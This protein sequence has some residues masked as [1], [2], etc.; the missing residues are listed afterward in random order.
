MKKRL[1]SYISIVVT[2]SLLL[3]FGLGLLVTR[4]NNNEITSDKLTEIT[5][6]LAS[7][8]D[9]NFDNLCSYNGNIRITVI[10]SNGTVIADSDEVDV[11]T[12]DNHIDREEVVAALKGAPTII[13]RYSSTIGRD[14]MYYAEKVS[15]G[16]DYVFI[17]TAMP[18][19]SISGYLVKTIPLMIF[20]LFFVLAMS[21]IVSFFVSDKLIK[22]YTAVKENLQAINNGNYKKLMPTESYSEINETITEINDIAEKINLSIATTNEEKNRLDYVVNNINDGIIAVDKDGNLQMV[23]KK[24]AE[25]FNAE[26]NLV[27]KG[28]ESLVSVEALNRAISDCITSHRDS[29]LEIEVN[30][31]IYLVTVKGLGFWKI[32]EEIAV[33]ILSDVTASKNN[34]KMRSEFFANASH[35]LKT[36]LTAIMGFNEIV[37]INNKDE[38]LKKPVSQIAKEADRM[39]NLI[40]DMLK[41]SKLDVGEAVETEKISLQ[42]VSAEVV[43]SLSTVIKEKNVIVSVNGEGT[44]VAGQTHIY[45]LAKNLIENAVKYNVDG[46]RVDVNIATTQNGVLFEVADSGIGIDVKH[47]SRIFER[48]YRV[49]KSR[50]RATGGTGLGL[51]IVKHVCLLY[52]ADITLKSKLGIGTTI[53]VLFKK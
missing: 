2:F 8:Y 46:G 1:L 19:E 28:Y 10:A 43:E 9:G 48:F 16:D 23:N 6:L 11:S 45:E 30:K 26:I 41:L 53:T 37:G 24:A 40:D 34:E 7:V 47:Q 13:T 50:S 20:I 32:G 31:S 18:T 15:V 4:S 21:S 51:A 49:E 44:V 22:P 52:N 12:L 14:M 39:L 17:R 27:G 35:E 5:D 29:M 42:E 36:P 38:S 33:A 25:I 3:M